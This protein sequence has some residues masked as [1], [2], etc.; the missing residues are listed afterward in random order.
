VASVFAAIVVVAVVPV[1]G[2]SVVCSTHQEHRTT[3]V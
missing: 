3:G 1:I 2:S